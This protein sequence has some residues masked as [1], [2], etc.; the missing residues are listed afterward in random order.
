[1]IG[2]VTRH[3][4]PHLHGFPHLHVKR[5]LYKWRFPFNTNSG[6]R[7]RKFQVPHGT[8]HFGCTDPAQATAR[9][10]IVLVSRLQ[11]SGTGVHTDFVKW[12]GTFRSDRPEMTRNGQRGPL[13]KLVPNIPVGPN[14]NGRSI[15]WTNWNFRNLGLNAKRPNIT[16]HL[17]GNKECAES[18]WPANQA[19]SPHT[20]KPAPKKGRKSFV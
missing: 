10:V 11:N 1:M 20:I 15:W 19:G 4:L 6:V 14:R 16:E 12:K 7:F 2:G 5:P 8:V 3:M 13:S 9:L 18:A 17:W